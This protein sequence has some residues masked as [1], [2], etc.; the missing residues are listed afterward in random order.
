[1]AMVMPGSI[2][3]SALQAELAAAMRPVSGA[4]PVPL[5][6][7]LN[8]VLDANL[9]SPIDVPGHANSAMDGW[10]FDGSALTQTP[11]H[12]QQVGIAYAGHPYAGSITAGECVRIMTGAVVPEG[13]DTVV[14]QE[15]VTVQGQQVLIPAGQ[16]RGQNVRLAGE[17]LARGAR[18][19]AAGTRLRP[20]HIGLAASLGLTHLSVRRKLRV[21]VFST[22]DELRAAGDPLVPGAI[23]DSNR[24]MLLGMLEQLGCV[25]TDLGLIPDDTARLEAA[26]RGAIASA[27]LILTSGGVSMGDADPVRLLLAGLGEVRFCKVDMRPGR[28]F[29]WGSL[30]DGS[31]S[32]MLFG[33][34]G[35][36]VAA[37]ISFILF[38]R[39]AL[40]QMMGCNDTRLPRHTARAA[41]AI[42]KKP[43]RTEYQRGLLIRQPD[44]L[45]VRLTG[46]QGSGMLSSLCQADCLIV[47]EEARGDVQPGEPVEVMPVDGLV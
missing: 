35:N 11:L 43:G 10:A 46:A 25:A 15:M 1:M 5:R 22:G 4:E 29:A 2:S 23:Y 31:R 42:P 17:D 36:P 44:G 3:V 16:R 30:S 41:T 9:L 7:A 26:L 14:M 18:A 8:R 24:A 47:L 28:P 39:P 13:A 33:L 19:L 38:V 32:S 12:L 40:L 45:H 37:A 6:Q 20:S 21:A 34:P 27:D